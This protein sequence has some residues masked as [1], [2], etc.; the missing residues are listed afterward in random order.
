MGLATIFAFEKL[1]YALGNMDASA[2]SPPAN[3][4]DEGFLR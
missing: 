2:Q 4:A 1:L 3:I